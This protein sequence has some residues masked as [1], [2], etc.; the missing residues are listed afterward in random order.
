M[1]LSYP[2]IDPVA[3][4]IGPIQLRWYGIAVA[5]GLLFIWQY[6]RY[7]IA[8]WKTSIYVNDIDNFVIWFF[9]GS[10]IGA[11]LLYIVLWNASYFYANPL[12]IFLIWEGGVSIHGAF[13]GGLLGIFLFSN[14]QKIP[15]FVLCDL[16]A[17]GTPMAIFLVRL[18]NFLNGELYGRQTTVPWA[19]V[20]PNGGESLRHPSQLY[21]A[22]LEGLALFALLYILDNRLKAH[23]RKGT[24]SSC[25]LIF[26][27]IFRLFCELFREPDKEVG[28]IGY[29]FTM[30]QVL[31]FPMLIAGV[32]VLALRLFEDRRNNTLK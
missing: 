18:G 16:A 11:R 2:A 15:F 20:F 24:L 10:I 29:D 28:L 8:K 3:I 27:S 26:Y 25:F 1:A 21:E 14:V 32:I 9:C 5:T 31:S 22:L 30:G 13:I 4:E 19:M 7:L 12:K 17:C 6:A 23:R